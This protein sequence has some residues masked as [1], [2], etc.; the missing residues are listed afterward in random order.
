MG[1]V[2][3]QFVDDAFFR[4]YNAALIESIVVEEAA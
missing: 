2:T 1:N 4:Q 3:A